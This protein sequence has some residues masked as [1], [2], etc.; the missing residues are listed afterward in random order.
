MKYLSVRQYNG[1]VDSQLSAMAK[2]RRI[3]DSAIH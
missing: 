2:E 1:L 3:Q